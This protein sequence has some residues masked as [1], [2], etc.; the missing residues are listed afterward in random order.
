MRRP[1]RHLR[2]LSVS[3]IV[4]CTGEKQP[5][6]TTGATSTAS[7]VRA[8]ERTTARTTAAL[9]TTTSPGVHWDVDSAVVADIDCDDRVDTAAVG[10]KDDEVRVGLVRGAEL[11]PPQVLAFAV[12]TAEQA[13]VC[14]VDVALEVE[15]MDK[16]LRDEEMDPPAGYQRSATCQGLA[17]GDGN[18]DSIHLY[19]NHDSSQLDWWRR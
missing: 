8:T 14:S 19:W 3:L 7:P 5:E 2:F 1:I 15:S 10:R 12:S 17:L 13:A 16:E 9:L 11:S 4:A 6:R 18:C